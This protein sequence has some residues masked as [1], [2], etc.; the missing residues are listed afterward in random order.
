MFYETAGDDFMRR[1]AN[2]RVLHEFRIGE[3]DFHGLF[4]P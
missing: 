1:E 4:H 2:S 3:T